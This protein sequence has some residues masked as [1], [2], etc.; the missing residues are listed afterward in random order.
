[1]SQFFFDESREN[2]PHALP[3]GETFHS[4]DYDLPDKYESGY[5]YWACFPGCLAD[6]DPIGPFRTEEDALA[7]A[8]GYGG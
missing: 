8:R 5:Y 2:E 1:M 3:D 7:D 6:S 4:I